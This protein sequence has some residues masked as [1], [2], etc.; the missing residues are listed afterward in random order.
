[1]DDSQRRI[2]FDALKKLNIDLDASLFDTS[3]R[4]DRSVEQLR[5]MS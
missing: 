1:V 3:N 4:L 5:L 2:A